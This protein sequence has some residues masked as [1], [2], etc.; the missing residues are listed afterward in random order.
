MREVSLWTRNVKI[1]VG[2][3]ALD[4]IW[5]LVFGVEENPIKLIVGADD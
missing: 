3:N 1:V 4:V 5:C 2:M